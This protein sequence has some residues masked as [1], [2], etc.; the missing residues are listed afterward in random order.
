MEKKLTPVGTILEY[1]DQKLAEIE[2]AH[3]DSLTAFAAVSHLNSVRK[4][5]AAQ[6]HEEQKV[7][8]ETYDI[9]RSDEHMSGLNV[10]PKN[11]AEFYTNNYRQK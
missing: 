7:I 3:P 8:E 6:L 4:V 9:A 1:I 5:A 2:S 10:V 11:G